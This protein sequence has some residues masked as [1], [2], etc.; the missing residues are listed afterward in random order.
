[1]P[2]VRAPNQRD[3]LLRPT[4][5]FSPPQMQPMQTIV[6]ATEDPEA[7][8]SRSRRALVPNYLINKP[9]GLLC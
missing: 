7:S 1:M 4:L 2:D 6:A 5:D 3:G 8:S 9:E